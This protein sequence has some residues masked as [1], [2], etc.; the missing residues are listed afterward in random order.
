MRWPPTPDDETDETREGQRDQQRQS[1][2]PDAPSPEFKSDKA[3]REN[4]SHDYS[5]QIRSRDTQKLA[6]VV[7]VVM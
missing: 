3:R 6:A 1:K 2:Q 5:T 4:G 7:D